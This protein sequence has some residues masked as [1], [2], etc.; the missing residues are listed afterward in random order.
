MGAADVDVA[1]PPFVEVATP[2]DVVEG[3]DVVLDLLLHAGTSVPA[4]AVAAATLATAIIRVVTRGSP[5][6]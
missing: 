6:G 5:I 1:E 3:S 2:D 4:S